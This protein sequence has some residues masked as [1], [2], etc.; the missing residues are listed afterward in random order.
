MSDALFDL[1]DF[2]ETRP[3]GI[4]ECG[5]SIHDVEHYDECLN[6]TCP[7]CHVAE[8]NG[9]MVLS[10]HA[11]EWRSSIGEPCVMQSWHWERV[12]CCLGCTNWTFGVWPCRN[13]A[14]AFSDP[15]APADPA[16]WMKHPDYRSWWYPIPYYPPT[17]RA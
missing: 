3:V 7:L 1:A 17:T 8:R 15:D 11:P 10:E 9:Y 12:A 2:A 6:A 14:C 13:G 5:H 16:L 4:L